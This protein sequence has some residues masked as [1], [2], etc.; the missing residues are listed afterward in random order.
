MDYI[1]LQFN[2][3][4]IMDLIRLPFMN[5]TIRYRITNYHFALTIERKKAVFVVDTQRGNRASPFTL[6]HNYFVVAEN[7]QRDLVAR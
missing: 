3:Q 2:C 4:Q 7:Q 1:S 6:Y 5:S